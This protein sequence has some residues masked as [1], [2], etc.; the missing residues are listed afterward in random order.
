[1]ETQMIERASQQDRMLDLYQNLNHWASAVQ[2]TIN[3]RNTAD[4]RAVFPDFRYCMMEL[5]FTVR[6]NETIRGDA[7]FT[8]EMNEWLNVD[9]RQSIDLNFGN[10]SM[11]LF[12][13]FAEKIIQ[14]V[15]IQ[16]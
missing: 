2:M 13:R 12:S 7:Q 1:M 4:L 8:A 3:F 6:F 10:K 15:V 11:K 14:A 5:Y 16:V 9:L